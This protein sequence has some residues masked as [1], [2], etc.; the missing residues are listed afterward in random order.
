MVGSD[1]RNGLEPSPQN[2]RH[3]DEDHVVMDEPPSTL[4][5]QMAVPTLPL[6][7]LSTDIHPLSSRPSDLPTWSVSDGSLSKEYD[8]DTWRMYDRIQASRLQSQQ[9]LYTF[10]S[11]AVD[12]MHHVVEDENHGS[13]Q[14]STRSGLP[15]AAEEDLYDDDIFDLDM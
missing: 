15:G 2:P 13:H 6:R 9:K 11:E 5:S 8:N 14:E 1:F 12:Q 10:V 7:A 4:Q 3:V